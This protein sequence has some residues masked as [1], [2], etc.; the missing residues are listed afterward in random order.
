MEI[1][2]EQKLKAWVKEALK[3]RCLLSVSTNE[4]EREQEEEQEEEQERESWLLKML[5]FD[6]DR[7]RTDCCSGLTYNKGLLTQCEK[8]KIE[9]SVY[10]RGCNCIESFI[11]TVEERKNTG[12]YT[13]IDRKGHKPKMYLD[14]LKKMNKSVEE[15]KNE[16]YRLGITINPEHL[17]EK[18]VSRGRPK[19]EKEIIEERED[20]FACVY[21]NID[22]S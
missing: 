4:Q 9:N 8:K 16:A 14:V 19:K 5:P 12:L 11:G 22:S 21:L 13:Y 3:E 10:C 20:L 2:I 18:I 15:V 7:I 6:S 1:I 17:K